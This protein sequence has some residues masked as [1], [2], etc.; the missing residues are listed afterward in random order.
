MAGLE[1]LTGGIVLSL[2]RM[3][4]VEIRTGS[5]F[6]TPVPRIG[7]TVAVFAAHEGSFPTPSTSR[8]VPAQDVHSSSAF[9]SCESP[10]QSA[11]SNRM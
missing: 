4:T 3:S 1:N 10:P 9:H 2:W 6:R 5:Q 7:P 8:C 11:Q